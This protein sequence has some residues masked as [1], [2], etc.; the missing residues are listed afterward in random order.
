MTRAARGSLAT[1]ALLAISLAARPGRAADPPAT[2]AEFFGGGSL[3]L[4]VRSI[5][6]DRTFAETF[7]F[8]E[9]KNEALALGGGLAYRTAAWH[10]ASLGLTFYTSQKV[11]A[12]PDS[13]GTG[14]LQG[15]EGFSVLAETF[16]QW[17]GGR[18]TVR[19]FRQRLESPVLGS[20]DFRMVPYTWPAWTVE[21]RSIPGLAVTASLVTH[22]KDWTSTKFVRIGPWI[23]APEVDAPTGLLGLVYE[24]P[25]KAFAAQAWGYYT[26]DVV[27]TVYLQADGRLPVGPGLAL[28]LSGQ[29]MAQRAVGAEVYPGARSAIGGLEAALVWKGSEARL[30]ATLSSHDGDFLNLFGTYPGF[31]SIMEEDNNLAGERSW[32]VGLTL[33]LSG[34]GVPGLAFLLDRTKAW[35]SD[36][37]PGMSPLD[38][39]ELDVELRYRLPRPV[40]GLLLRLRYANVE[41][42]LDQ[43]SI[44]GRDFDEYRVVLKYDLPL[45]TYLRK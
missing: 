4:Q 40:E 13:T 7:Q 23:G 24:S 38:Q 18:T 6:M 9:V 42:A 21:N 44:Y 12:P 22:A 25:G 30:A 35:V 2:L 17:E 3:D 31:T 16:L 29:A 11:W 28:T 20:R 14:L 10:G 19:L 32:L 33:D 1:L 41:S 27:G 37:M 15:D 39:K 8:P 43:G 34:L 45:E 36:P 5:F 26:Q